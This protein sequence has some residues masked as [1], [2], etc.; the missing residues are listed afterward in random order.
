ML[1]Y[2]RSDVRDQGSYP[3]VV[4]WAGS[5][6]EGD[7]L[8]VLVNNAGIAHWEGFDAITKD[9]MLD[10]LEINC[11]APLMLAKVVY[12]LCAVGLF[13]RYMIEPVMRIMSLSCIV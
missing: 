12:A 8:N 11:I 9:L 13:L 1:N 6:L 3:A 5:L 4:D 7:G 10:C 2:A